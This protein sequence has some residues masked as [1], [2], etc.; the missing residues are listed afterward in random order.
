MNSLRSAISSHAQIIKRRPLLSNILL[1]AGLGFT[2]DVLCQRVFEGQETI[3]N[4]RLLALTAFASLYQGGFCYLLYAQY[5]SVLPAWF[6]KTKLREG[7]GSSLLDNFVHVPFVYTPMYYVSTG[8]M[9][10][11]SSQEIEEQMTEK[12]FESLLACWTL[13]IPLQSINF[14]FVPLHLQATFVNAGCLVW[15][16]VLGYVA[17]SPKDSLLVEDTES[18]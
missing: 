18:K 1:G 11:F 6:L 17:N 2:G 14:S 8:I 10:G 12:Y 13:W 15:N 9:R 3:D 4:K 16:V 5:R 7:I